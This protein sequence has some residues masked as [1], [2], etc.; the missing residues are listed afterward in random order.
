MLF[1]DFDMHVTVSYATAAVN[2]YRRY[3]AALLQCQS[4]CDVTQGRHQ[5]VYMHK[6]CQNDNVHVTAILALPCRKAREGSMR[7]L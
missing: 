6:I 1:T 2:M 3:A 4:C 7:S 5:H